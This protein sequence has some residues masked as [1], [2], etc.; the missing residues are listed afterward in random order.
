MRGLRDNNAV[1]KAMILIARKRAHRKKPLAR[2]PRRDVDTAIGNQRIVSK[3]RPAIVRISFSLLRGAQVIK[4]IVAEYSGTSNASASDNCNNVCNCPKESKAKRIAPSLN[5]ELP[6]FAPLLPIQQLPPLV[7][8]PPKLHT[9]R[10]YHPRQQQ[11]RK[12][13]PYPRF[14]NPADVT[15]NIC[16]LSIL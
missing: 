6:N 9:K 13:F 15:T 10:H 12:H 2:R 3:D 1:S 4:I 11:H 16:R 14:S 8:P 5:H 7:A